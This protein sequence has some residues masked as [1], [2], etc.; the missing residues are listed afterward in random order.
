MNVARRAWT[1]AFAAALLA[2][3]I[4]LDL[5]AAPVPKPQYVFVSTA[6]EQVCMYQGQDWIA[7]E[8][9]VDGN[10][11]QTISQRTPRANFLRNPTGPVLCVFHDRGV[12]SR[13][14]SYE[15]RSGRLIRGVQ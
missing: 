11:S 14:P 3:L 7:G 5:R 10:F 12:E 4:L 8:L 1:A 9:D 15:F 2:T 13:A 6:N